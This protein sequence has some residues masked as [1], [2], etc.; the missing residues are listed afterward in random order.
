MRKPS[1]QKRDGWWFLNIPAINYSG[2][3]YDWVSCMVGLKLYHEN[4]DTLGKYSGNLNIL[5]N[6]WMDAHRYD[7]YYQY[8]LNDW[9]RGR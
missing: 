6:K 7:G 9:N 2:G 3:W 5:I 4:S 8:S 1:I